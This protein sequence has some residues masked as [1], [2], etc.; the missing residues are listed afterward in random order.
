MILAFVAAVAAQPQPLELQ[1][2]LAG[3]D[4]RNPAYRSAIEKRSAA[5]GKALAARAVN[6]PTLYGDW[7]DGTDEDYQYATAEL[8]QSTALGPQVG[9]IWDADWGT[10]PGVTVDVPLADGLI[11][12]SE[13]LALIQAELGVDAAEIDV[14]KTELDLR[15]QAASAWYSWVAA[16]RRLEIADSQLELAQE[17]QDALQIAVNAGSIPAINVLDNRRAL[18]ERQAAVVKARETVEKAAA[19]LSLYYR[20][21]QGRPIVVGTDRLPQTPAIS[22]PSLDLDADQQL[23]RARPQVRSLQISLESQQAELD[24]A[25]NGML[26]ELSAQGTWHPQEWS[27]GVGFSMSPAFRAERGKLN[28]ARA[29]LASLEADFQNAL[30]T[31]DAALVQAHIELQRRWEAV[32]LAQQDVEITARA[33]GLE[34]TAFNLGSSEVFRLVQREQQLAAAQND[35]VGATL[36]Y[37]L[38]GLKRLAL[39]GHAPQP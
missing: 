20:D 15:L 2:L 30:D 38:A 17:R 23:A 16:G 26:P 10:T 8:I 24:R 3:V 6:T 12:G 13:R 27:A 37:Q 39:V 1:E 9:L 25:R 32:E 7:S 33:L 29:Q 22:A 35:L 18:V 31:L 4:A 28:A 21:A 5:E 36:D 11:F 14:E 19:A 34:N